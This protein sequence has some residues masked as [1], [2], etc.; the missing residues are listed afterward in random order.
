MV[1]VGPTTPPNGT[2]D[3][4]WYNQNQVLSDCE[5][6]NP[7]RTGVIEAVSCATWNDQ[8][9]THD[10]GLSYKLWWMQNLPGYNNGLYYNGKPLINWWDVVYDFD[11]VL[12]NESGLTVPDKVRF[13][14][15]KD[16]EFDVLDLTFLIQYIFSR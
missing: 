7:Q 16:G 9:C 11:S 5:N 3:Y 12:A 4:D 14:A 10:D 13:D 1:V 2:K 8:A 15:N 6:W